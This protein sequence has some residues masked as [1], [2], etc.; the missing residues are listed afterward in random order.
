MATSGQCSGG[1]PDPEV[2]ELAGSMWLAPVSPVVDVVGL[3]LV[4]EAQGLPFLLGQE[5]QNETASYSNTINFIRDM[6]ATY[7]LLTVVS[8]IIALLN[9]VP[10]GLVVLCRPRMATV[11][12]DDPEQAGNDR[13]RMA[14]LRGLMGFMLLV[15]ACLLMTGFASNSIYSSSIYKLPQHTKHFQ[16]ILSSYEDDVLRTAECVVESQRKYIEESID[17]SYAGCKEALVR[18]VSKYNLQGRASLP[19]I[20]EFLDKLPSASEMADDLEVCAVRL[21]QM[22]DQLEPLMLAG[23]PEKPTQVACDATR[24]PL[25]T[26]VLSSWDKLRA[27]VQALVLTPPDVFGTIKLLRS[28]V[29]EDH[30]GSMKA[31]ITQYSNMAGDPNKYMTNEIKGD[32]ERLLAAD[33]RPQGQVQ[34]YRISLVLKRFAKLVAW[35]GEWA[36]AAKTPTLH[37]AANLSQLNTVHLAALTCIWGLSVFALIL[38]FT[39][40]RR[41]SRLLVRLAEGV[42]A[43][44]VLQVHVVVSLMLFLGLVGK[45]GVCEPGLEPWSEATR[46]AIGDYVN[47]NPKSKWMDGLPDVVLRCHAKHTIYQAFRTE[48]QMGAD[49][50]VAAPPE[51]AH[52]LYALET[53][54]P[55]NTSALFQGLR[56]NL[57]DESKLSLLKTIMGLPLAALGAS[58]VQKVKVNAENLAYWLQNTSN[59]LQA[60]TV[61]ISPPKQSVPPSELVC[62]LQIGV[63]LALVLLLVPVLVCDPAPVGVSDTA[64][65]DVFKLLVVGLSVLDYRFIAHA[66]L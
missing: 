39:G 1:T 26:Q 60:T 11:D 29:E 17:P 24:Q 7:P 13:V 50:S 53:S 18:D 16:T 41:T 34:E 3:L 5:N 33:V 40:E 15:L 8:V 20:T 21:R 54:A 43:C 36:D 61:A 66:Y 14:M 37:L 10:G 42:F 12:F 65:S 19:A 58:E 6:L 59:A 51:L 22:R 31:V 28:L 45:R 4:G 52:A 44:F 32:W 48:S 25:C 2:L 35:V 62:E 30:I 57:L 56:T 23:V 47:E 9:L 64:E 38:G 46:T 27:A 55:I 49:K 63:V